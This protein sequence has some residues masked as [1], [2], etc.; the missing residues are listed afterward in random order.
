MP[1]LAPRIWSSLINGYNP[2]ANM[3]SS[4]YN[5]AVDDLQT[6]LQAL[7]KDLP[8]NDQA[9]AQWRGLL[10]TALDLWEVSHETGVHQKLWKTL[11]VLLKANYYLESNQSLDRLHDESWYHYTLHAAAGLRRRLPPA[12]VEQ[13]I[14]QFSYQLSQRDSLTLNMPLHLLLAMPYA[15]DRLVRLAVLL[16][17]RPTVAGERNANGDYPLTLARASGYGRKTGLEALQR[18]APH[19]GQVTTSDETARPCSIHIHPILTIDV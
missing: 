1:L 3:S 18:A 15:A 13:L 17:A 7:W 16:E 14:V 19:T 12:L 10:T 2:Y 8:S 11:C 4:T 6:R 9:K 5:K